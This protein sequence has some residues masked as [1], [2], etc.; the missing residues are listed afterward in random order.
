MSQNQ[1]VPKILQE[2]ERMIQRDPA[3]R[4]LLSSQHAKSSWMTGQL[5]PAGKSLAEGAGNVAIVTG[6]FI[7]RGNPP[8]AETDGPPGAALLADILQ[9]LGR[10]VTIL[11][12]ERCATGVAAACVGA[13]LSEGI[14]RAVR[15]EEIDAFCNSAESRGLS[16]L[17]AIER[18][19]PSDTRESFAART[20]GD[21]DA[22]ARFERE[23]PESEHGRCFNM[24]GERIDEFTGRLHE[25]FERLPR[26][27]PGL[28]TIGIGDGGN[29]IGMGSIPWRILAESLMPPSTPK[30]LCRIPTDWTLVA[31][32]SNWGAF[33]L[34]ASVA[35]SAGRVDLLESWDATRHQQVLERMVTAGPAVDGVTRLQEAT[36]DGL[37]F[38]TYI[39]PWEG[40]RRVLG[41]P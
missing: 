5:A 22:A 39:Q 3:R 41:F 8:G 35:L 7:P 19:G 38:L 31:G 15:N 11:T 37:P 9:R 25:L 30:I 24:R 27:I 23:V 14:V 10:R 32:T 36:V 29:E 28:K 17:I 34:A 1:S 4:G 33:G 6:F 16:H 18:V 13:G 20:H 2:M 21:T 40:I 12:D 26:A